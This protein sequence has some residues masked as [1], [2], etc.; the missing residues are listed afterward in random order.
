MVVDLCDDADDCDGEELDPDTL[1]HL[2]MQLEN[3]MAE[4]SEYHSQIWK[5]MLKNKT[6]N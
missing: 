4:L 2:Q 1:Q 3:A 5:I 6:I